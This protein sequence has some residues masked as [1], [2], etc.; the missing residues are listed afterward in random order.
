MIGYTLKL[1]KKNVFIGGTSD[2][3]FINFLGIPNKE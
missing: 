3:P 1:D 2:E